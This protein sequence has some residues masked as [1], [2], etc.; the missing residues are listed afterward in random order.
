MNWV[1]LSPHLDDAV[2]SCGGLI[3]DLVQ[4]GHTAEIW[5]ICAGDPP[6]V[7]LS[8]LAQSLHARWGTGDNPIEARRE[9][10]RR[11]CAILGAATRHFSIPDCI[12]RRNPTTGAPLILKN[13]ELFQPLPEVEYPL[14]SDLSRQLILLQPE[15]SRLISPIALGGHIDHH[16]VRRAAEMSG[17]PLLYYADYPY[18]IQSSEDQEK[19]I[20]PGWKKYHQPVS[21]ES[22][23]KWQAAIAEHRSQI[24][25]FWKSRGDMESAIRAYWQSGGGSLLWGNF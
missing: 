7:P 19:W 11:S 22:L 10:D 25:T 15:S 16:L 1:F 23:A 9:E 24:S 8:P 13:E 17:Q 4:F 18:S 14:A 6:P 2:L 21:M 5:T 20:D 12:Y 3:A